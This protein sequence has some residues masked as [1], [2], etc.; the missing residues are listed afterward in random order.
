MADSACRVEQFF[1]MK[2]SAKVM[3]KEHV[4]KLGIYSF[5]NA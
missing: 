5:L 3:V 4:F 1:H 2:Q